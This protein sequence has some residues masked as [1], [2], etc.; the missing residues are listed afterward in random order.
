MA[1]AEKRVRHDARTHFEYAMRMSNK[2]GAAG[3]RFDDMREP[4]VACGFDQAPGQLEL[5]TRAS[6]VDAH[7]WV[8]VPASFELMITELV[9]LGYLDLRVE[10]V[11]EAPETEFYARLRKGKENLDPAHMQMRRKGLMD[12]I[13]IELAEQS[14]Q[15]SVSPFNTRMSEQKDYYEDRLAQERALLAEQKAQLA[16]EKA[17]NTYYERRIERM[18]SSLSWKVTTPLRYL[19]RARPR[20]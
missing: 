17:V 20:T 3:W 9:G 14:R 1:F 5:A 13:I 7:A 16:H 19:G 8:F 15:I 12:R 11:A 2:G 10:D 18:R 6:Y 4:V